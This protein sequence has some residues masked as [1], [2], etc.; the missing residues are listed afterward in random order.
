ME[1]DGECAHR[2]PRN[3][4]NMRGAAHVADAAETRLDDA[5][6]RFVNV[7]DEVSADIGNNARRGC[8]SAGNAAPEAANPP[9]QGFAG[10]DF[11][12]CRRC[13]EGSGRQGLPHAPDVC[14]S[15][16]SFLIYSA[17]VA[18]DFASAEA[19]R[20]AFRSPLDPFGR[21]FSVSNVTFRPSDRQIIVP[22][23]SVRKTTTSAS[24]RRLRVLSAGWP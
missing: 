16:F 9:L 21:H 12:V 14:H 7:V 22:C 5:S 3:Q 6:R 10:Q 19:K 18:G 20:W 24:R 4:R 15:R 23:S 13:E 1:A 8:A 2:M 11:I 17:F